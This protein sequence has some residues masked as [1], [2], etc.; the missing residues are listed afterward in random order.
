MSATCALC[1][2]LWQ[3]AGR[4]FNAAHAKPCWQMSQHSRFYP[5]LFVDADG[6]PGELNSS[7]LRVVE[8]ASRACSA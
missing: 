3:L 1:A 4:L 2:G 6:V 5:A 8:L 7:L